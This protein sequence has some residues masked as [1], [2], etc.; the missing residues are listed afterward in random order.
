M[1]ICYCFLL[2]QFDAVA[3]CK[4]FRIDRDV[5]IFCPL[6]I[7]NFRIENGFH[8]LMWIKNEHCAC[9]VLLF[10]GYGGLRKKDECEIHRR[11][12]ISKDFISLIFFSAFFH[13]LIIPGVCG[14]GISHFKIFGL[15]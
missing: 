13:L 11:W 5:S 1:L 8:A 3:I 9:E 12:H 14:C 15:H 6:S 10:F 4:L 7:A 2:L